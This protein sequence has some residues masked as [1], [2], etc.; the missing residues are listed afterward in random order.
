MESNQSM[1]W[2]FWNLQYGLFRELKSQGL[3][4]DLKP[5]A[6]VGVHGPKI[7]HE[8]NSGQVCRLKSSMPS[9][10]KELVRQALIWAE[11][12]RTSALMYQLGHGSL[13][14][15]AIANLL[16]FDLDDKVEIC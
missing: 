16:E 14:Q 9:A 8:L 2:V 13:S 7:V 4:K 15:E 6:V 10:S 1:K 5:R 3:V 12:G 11:R